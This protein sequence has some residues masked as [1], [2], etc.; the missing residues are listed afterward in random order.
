MSNLNPSLEKV[1]PNFGQ[2]FT[3]K[4]FDE[5]TLNKFPFW[6][7]HPE[8]EMVYISSGSGKRHVGNHISYY[9][10][11][12]LIF[13]G[14]NLPHYGFTDRFTGRGSE[15]VV[16]M[17]PDFLGK[18]F[19]DIPEM[20]AIS[21][22]FERS[23]G[24]LTFH[25]N[26]KREVGERLEEMHHM[27][28]FERV[29]T[30]IKILNMLAKSEDY[31]LL[32]ASAASLVV[33]HKDSLRIDKVYKHIRN[34]FQEETIPLAD[35]AELVNM[36]IPSFCRFFKKHTNKT[37]T[38][39]VNEFRIVHATKLLHETDESIASICFDC[40]FNN[41]SHFN[42]HFKKITGKSPSQYRKELNPVPLV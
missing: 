19:F 23:K 27:S 30:L 6:H 2:S 18:G 28:H 14:P 38:Q 5:A 7:F 12:D 1:E 13:L 37:F 21:K 35:V 32:N 36:T 24:G 9:K 17:R 42:R 26:I 3:Y 31:T 16:Q 40:G 25:G 41:F 10:D 22:F 4:K 20:E 11:G 33:E 8:M 15:V 39:F 34:H 29:L